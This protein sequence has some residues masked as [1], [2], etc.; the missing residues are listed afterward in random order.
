MLQ[1]QRGS[2]MFLPWGNESHPVG[3]IDPTRNGILDTP[4][5]VLLDVEWVSTGPWNCMMTG[6]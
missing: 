6:W 1:E 2:S 3:L 4:V 5:D